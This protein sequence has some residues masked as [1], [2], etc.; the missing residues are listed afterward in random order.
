MRLIQQNRI[1]EKVLDLLK[2]R[3]KY[4]QKKEEALKAQYR[5][6]RAKA[7]KLFAGKKVKLNRMI[8]TTQRENTNTWN[9]GLK[10]I[11]RR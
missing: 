2:L 10:R 5:R 7:A 4:C 1:P 11:D 9:K 3:L 6:L 8:Q